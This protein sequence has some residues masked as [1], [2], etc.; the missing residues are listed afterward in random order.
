MAKRKRI[1]LI[2]TRP[3]AEALLDAGQAAVAIMQESEDP[4]TLATAEAAE[5]ALYRLEEAMDAAG[6]LDG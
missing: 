2:L 6:W 3:E 5:A 4:A 1:A